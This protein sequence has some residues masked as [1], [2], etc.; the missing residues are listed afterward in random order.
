MKE[1]LFD[2]EEFKSRVD[3]NKPV[4]WTVYEKCI[5]PKHGVF[6]RMWLSITGLDVKDGHII[7]FYQETTISIA[8]KEKK[9]KIVEEWRKQY[10]VPLKATPG[11]WLPK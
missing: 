4:H 5:D 10:V 7:E 11:E 9:E 3:L 8:E 1:R 6:Y 2:Y